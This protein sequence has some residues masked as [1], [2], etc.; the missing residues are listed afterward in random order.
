MRQKKRKRRRA[1]RRIVKF[2]CICICIVAALMVL[3]TKVFP[4]VIAKNNISSGYE[5]CRIILDAGHGG[6]DV[7]TRG[8]G[9]NYDILEKDVNLEM[10]MRMKPLLEELGV[11]VVLTRGSDETLSLKE[12]VK[13]ANDNEADLF[14]SI[15]CNYYE[16]D[17]S[18]RG[19]ECYYYKRSDSGKQY[20]E[21]IL[22]KIEGSGYVDTRNAK[23]SNFY[24]L[25]HT[26][27]PAVLVELGYFSNTE[28][29]KLLSEEKYQE[30]LANELVEGIVDVLNNSTDMQ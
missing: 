24:V 7:G 14:V 8:D 12:R 9:V 11:E 1:M 13:I 21:E 2:V 26:K 28:E 23:G 10:V 6:D 22:G 20:A 19:L 18:I 3:T 25:K 30:I 29:C 4:S 27:A 16:E 17:A 5:K 15:H